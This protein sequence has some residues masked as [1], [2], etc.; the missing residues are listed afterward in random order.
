MASEPI[1]LPPGPALPLRTIKPIPTM[2][3]EILFRS[4]T[5]ARWALLLDLF[6]IRWDYEA[7]GY[8]LAS[9][10]YLPD[11]WL[12]RFECFAEVKGVAE[13]WDDLS[14]TKVRELSLTTRKWVLLLDEMQARQQ[15]VRALVPQLDVDEALVLWI[16]V[17][18][19]VDLGRLWYE[20]SAPSALSEIDPGWEAAVACAKG[21]RFDGSARR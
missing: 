15:H 7:E 18:R 21:M 5:E 11:F 4:R 8:Q 13:Q 2:Y 12:P 3:R 10:W 17:P 20:E 14:R 9:C 1:D 16:D 19:S 6:G